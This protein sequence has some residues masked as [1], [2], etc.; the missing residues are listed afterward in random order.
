MKFIRMIH[1]NFAIMQPFFYKVSVIFNTLLPTFSGTLYT[2]VV[3]LP[4]ST[5]VHITR[6]VFEFAII[7]KRAPT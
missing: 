3:K 4:A 1:K 7:C 2:N 6:T 5:S